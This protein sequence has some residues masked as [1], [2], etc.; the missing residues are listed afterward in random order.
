MIDINLIRENPDK[1]RKGIE[2]KHYDAGLVDAFLKIDADWRANKQEADE[3][4][5][6]QKTFGPESRDEAKAVKEKVAEKEAVIS[7]LEKE[8]QRVL[9]QIPNIP[10]DDVPEGKDD[11]E[12]VV[13]RQ[14]GERPQ[15]DFE[16]KDYLTL[17]GRL[18]DTEQAVKVASSRFG[19]IFGD[20]ARLEFALVKLAMDTLEPYGFVPT[21]PPVMVKPEVMRGM[22]K[23]KFLEAGDAFY[24]QD[25]NLYLVGSSEHSIGP[26]HMDNILE[27]ET[28]PRRYMGFST[29]FR[30][31]AGSYG[32]D[33]KGILRVHQFDKV[34]M[35]S[36]SKPEDSE[37]EHKFL[38]GREEEMLGKLKLPYQ[39]MAICTGDM[40]F[41]DYRQFDVETWLPGQ[42]KYRETMSCSNTGDF[43]SR[44]LNIKYRVKSTG[45]LKYIH[46][47]NATAF[48]IGRMLIA[49]LENY[50]TKAGDVLVPEAL[51]A[52][53][54]KEKL[55]I[56][57]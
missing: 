40:G 35:F 20:L 39:V 4:R 32:K 50:Q 21:I 36:F 56:P 2:R 22:G 1:V 11:S 17:A 47:L 13:L 54:G 51:Q 16:P 30:R 25:D 44:G 15:F 19:Y 38:L 42:G 34:E 9:E 3:L 33:T 26:F 14:V 12:N 6:K 5:A 23:Q 46:T 18:I 8:R 10:A 27:E 52:F 28:L 57:K 55:S 49:I 31:E 45:E 48:A 29:C 41:G 37:E 24:L 53:V 7:G 43:Q